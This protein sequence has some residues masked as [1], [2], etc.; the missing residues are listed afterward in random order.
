ME[1]ISQSQFVGIMREADNIRR[2]YLPKHVSIG[3]IVKRVK[4]CVLDMY[5]SK[6]VIASLHSKGF[7]FEDNVGER[8]ILDLKNTKVFKEYVSDKNGC[9]YDMYLVTWEYGQVA[10][11]VK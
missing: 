2:S 4:E 9:V 3:D 10:Y 11:F 1:K 7:V 5:T 6:I 8:S